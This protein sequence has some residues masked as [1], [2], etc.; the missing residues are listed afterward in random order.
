MGC[1][2]VETNLIE[3]R[4]VSSLEEMVGYGRGVKVV[5]NEVYEG[6]LGSEPSVLDL[7]KESIV[8]SSNISTRLV[9]NRVFSAISISRL[10]TEHY[11]HLDKVKV[12]S[13]GKVV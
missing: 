3:L 2:S 12:E 4:D 8:E 7:L 6:E 10:V 5:E 11:V 1:N 9:L 13:R